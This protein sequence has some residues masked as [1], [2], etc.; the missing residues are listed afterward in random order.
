MDPGLEAEI[1]S[2]PGRSLVFDVEI[3]R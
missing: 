1:V 3:E 2:G